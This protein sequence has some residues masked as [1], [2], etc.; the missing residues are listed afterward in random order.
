[1]S[2]DLSGYISEETE[3]KIG[4]KKFWFSNLT[5][6]DL[7]LIRKRIKEQRKADNK[8]RREEIFAEAK[9]VGDIDT[10]ELL[11]Y[12]DQ[13]LS[14]VELEEL[15]SAFD[16]IPHLCFLS[17]KHHYKDITEEQVAGLITQNDLP[18]IMK[19]IN[20][21]EEEQGIKVTMKQLGYKVKLEDGETKTI[22]ELLDGISKKKRKSIKTK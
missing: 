3:V 14:D 7:G 11:K 1:M 13:P 2:I 6:T 9:D 15:M 5:I 18:A 12:L 22:S 20:P 10:L 4:G 21:E 16:S 8:K 19:A 17:L